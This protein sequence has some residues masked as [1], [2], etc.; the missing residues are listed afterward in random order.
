[1]FI[2]LLEDESDLFRHKAVKSMRNLANHGERQLKG[3][4]ARLTRGTK[5]EFRESITSAIP[6]FIRL[7]EDESDLVRGETVKSINDL[8]YHG[9]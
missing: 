5:V 2:R 4:T 1:L 6:L 8:A 3:I 7:L 9:E